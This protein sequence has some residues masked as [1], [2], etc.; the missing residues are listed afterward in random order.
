M[1]TAPR[2]PGGAA[3]PAGTIALFYQWYNYDLIRRAAAT[4]YF[5]DR[6]VSGYSWYFTCTKNCKIQFDILENRDSRWWLYI[7]DGTSSKTITDGLVVE[8]KKGH[9][10]RIAYNHSDP[11]AGSGYFIIIANFVK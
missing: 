3:S 6:G 5:T 11:V 9:Q 1:S 10:Y 8:L 7:S 2:A 4:A